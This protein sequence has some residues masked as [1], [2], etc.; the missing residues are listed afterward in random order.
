MQQAQWFLGIDGGGT[1]TEALL[2]QDVR[3]AVWGKAGPSNPHAVGVLAAAKNVKAAVLSAEKAV[4][5]KRPYHTVIGLAGMDTPRDVM[6]M[7]R[8]LTNEMRGIFMPGWKLVNDIVIAYRSGT[9]AKH[10]AVVIAG[11]GSN[12]FA[13]GP[14]GLAHAGGRGHRLA[15]E[16]S[17]YSQGLAALHAV[18]KADDGRGPKTLLTKYV[19]TH[20]HVRKP[21]DLVRVV[22]DPAFGKPQIASLAPYVQLAAERGDAVAREIFIAAARELALLATTVIRKSGL[23]RA[24]FPLVTVGGIF[25]CPIILPVHFRAVVR[26]TAPNVVFIRPPQRPALGA[27]LMASAR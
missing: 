22:Y 3:R 20:F 13:R 14:R 1:K 25:K 19:L 24:A 10:G 2:G 8:A 9:S 23:Q 11:T 4:G 21:S 12:A 7:H 18:T 26:R 5:R 17:G 27:W 16:G 15:D 6:A